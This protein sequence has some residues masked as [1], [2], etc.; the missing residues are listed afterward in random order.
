MSRAVNRTSRNTSAYLLHGHVELV[1]AA[2]VVDGHP[3]G[4]AAGVDGEQA[5]V[6]R[7]DLGDRRTIDRYLHYM[8]FLSTV[9]N[10]SSITDT[11]DIFHALHIKSFDI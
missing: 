6:A 5:E 11:T 9:T 3:D 2:V 8:V 10:K 7:H 4:L 1:P